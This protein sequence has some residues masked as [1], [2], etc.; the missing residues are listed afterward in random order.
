MFLF[1]SAFL[2]G[3]VFLQTLAELPSLLFLSTMVAISFFLFFLT[4]PLHYRKLLFGFI[5]GFVYSAYYAHT[6]LAWTLPKLWEGKPVQVKGYIAT[7]PVTS[8]QQTS[9]LFA[10]KEIN[11]TLI[12]TRVLLRLT[13]RHNTLLLV[14]GDE[15]EFQVKLRRVHSVQNPG[16]FDYEAWALQKGIRA[17]GYVLPG[18]TTRQTHD[19]TY[20]FFLEEF[21]YLI[22]KKIHAHLPVSDTSHWLPALLV[23]ERQNIPPSQWQVLRSTGTNHLMAIAGLH[24]GLLASFTHFLMVSIWRQFPSLLIYMPAKEAAAIAMLFS[25]ILYSALAG[26]S[27]PTQRACIMLCVFIVTLLMRI[28]INAWHAWSLAL[29]FVMMVNPFAVMTESFCLSFATIALIIYGMRGR[30]R[31]TGWWWKWGRV[32]WVIALG[33]IPLSLYLFQSVSLVAFIANIIAIPILGC[34][35]L[36]L[37]FLGFIFLFIYPSATSLCFIAAD[38]ILALLWALLSHMSAWTYATWALSISHP[39]MLLAV[40][41]GILCLLMPAGMCGRWLGVLFIMPIFLWKSERP[42]HEAYWLE[43]LDVGQGLAAVVQTKNHCLVYDAGPKYRNGTDMGERVVL[44]YLLRQQQNKIDMLVVSHGDNDHAGGAHAIMKALPITTIK[45]SVPEKFG[46]DVQLCLAGQKWVW[47]GVTFEFIYPTQ[48]QLNLGNDSSCVL[49]IDNGQYVTLLTGDIE[50]QAEKF[51]LAFSA[52]KLGVNI[53]IA[54]HHGS[55]TSGNKD[56][57]T[58]SHPDYVLYAVGYRNQYRFPH[59]EVMRSYDAIGAKQ[60]STASS[61]AIGFHIN[62]NL[63]M[64]NP[65]EYRMTHKKY[66]FDIN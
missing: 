11:K 10:I 54:P 9:F 38:K 43:L 31:P 25:S 15:W 16:S 29:L 23:G 50:K 47:D 55:K 34:V 2:S 64:S 12:P 46:R 27:I 44:P 13:I 17:V 48:A 61:G 32:Q 36:P 1:A 62:K 19:H 24:I 40:I 26:F 35:I 8:E 49:R 28:K 66:W 59:A 6:L 37:C 14:P 42:Q 52:E 33:L 39:L 18:T 60:L 20:T 41:T 21:R 65:S 57:I 63:P 58:A 22:W 56:F 7:L 53:L 4:K 51:L 30:L 5:I 3:S 45:S